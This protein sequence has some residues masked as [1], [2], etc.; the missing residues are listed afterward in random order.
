MQPNAGVA[1]SA[2]LSIGGQSLPVSQAAAS[3]CSYTLAPT[4]VSVDAGGGDQD[5]SVS[6]GAGCAW[7]VTG[8]PAWVTVSAGSGSGNGSFRVSVQ[9]NSGPARSATLNVGTTSLSITQAAAV[10]CSY[11]VTPGNVSVTAAGGAKPIGVATGTGCAWS[12]TG[13]PPWVT[14]S[15]TSGTGN[16]T[17]TVSVQSNS[18]A[19]R[20]TT[21]HIEDAT[22]LIS[23]D[24][25]CTFSL[26][27]STYNPT[28]SGGSTQVA[29]TGTPGCAWTT[30]N[31]PAWIGVT[32]G[33]GTGN[34]TVTLNV[35]ANTGA[36]RTATLTI[37]GAPFVVTQA[38]VACSFDVSPLLISANADG[39]TKKIQV[40]TASNCSW[41]A[42]V[43]DG[44]W[45]HL[46]TSG[47]T[48]S[49]SVN[50]VVD[51]NRSGSVRS[52]SVSV[53]GQTVNIGQGK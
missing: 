14:L 30:T 12:V 48:G 11:S 53:A 4:S 29:V 35:Q 34:G 22:L 3:T 51:K 43:I 40:T 28:A 44:D 25:A 8:A 10:A 27:S 23:Q 41:T 33:S 24:G 45:L 16:G 18:G 9:S 19:A 1:R 32:G 21:L 49:G 15:K 31:A 17:F 47:G 37:A 7:S 26:G 5:I 39:G 36:S 50:V 20:S 42:S 52:G 46:S 13:A 38:A 2:T 6:A